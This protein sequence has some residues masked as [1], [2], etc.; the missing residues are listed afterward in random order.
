MK[1][2]ALAAQI[3]G[4]V[5]RE[6]LSPADRQQMCELLA[7][8]FEGVTPAQFEHDLAEKNWV[9]QIRREGRLIGFSTLLVCEQVFEGHPLT[10]IYSGDTIMAPEAW[11]SPLL[12]R[13]WIAAV[14][15]L[16]AASPAGPCYWL[17]LTSGFRTYRFLKVFWREFFPHH[18]RPTPACK[19]RLLQHLAARRYGKMYDPVSGIVRFPHPQRLR[20]TLSRLPAGRMRDPDI[21]Y[22][23][24]RNPGHAAGD[25]LVC[26]AEISE[27]NLTRA[28]RRML[29]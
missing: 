2:A 18:T 4:L 7:R 29:T 5:M 12:A 1:A 20:G 22:F 6:A 11:G 14:S 17:L 16:R 19:E 8:H 28:G 23:L 27:A 3:D 13:T 24:A 10:A 21:A 9:V 26:L 15:Q 25:E